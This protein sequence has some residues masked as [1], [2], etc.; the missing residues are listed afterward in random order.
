MDIYKKAKELQSI[1]EEIA[2]IDERKDQLKNAKSVIEKQIVGE[3]IKQH[4]KRS[5]KFADISVTRVKKTA[6]KIIDNSKV[7]NLVPEQERQSFYKL[8]TL[9][10]KVFAESSFKNTGEIVDGAQKVEGE[11]LKV[12]PAKKEDK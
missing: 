4:D 7:L 6:I 1:K 8:D 3:M 11:Y 10:L 2:K 9:M 5:D 12:T